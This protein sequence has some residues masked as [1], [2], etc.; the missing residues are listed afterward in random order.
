M[1]ETLFR[2]GL[3]NG[4]T[5]LSLFAVAGWGRGLWNETCR[6]LTGKFVKAARIIAIELTGSIFNISSR[7]EPLKTSKKPGRLSRKIC[8]SDG[9]G[10]S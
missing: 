9:G 1:P 7:T 2:V 4:E 6:A 3:A 8:S 10:Q 5:S